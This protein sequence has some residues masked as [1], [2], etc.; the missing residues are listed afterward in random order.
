MIEGAHVLVVV[1]RAAA[2]AV[3]TLDAQ[4]ERNAGHETDG[5]D[6]GPH[7]P[8]DGAQG[9]WRRGRRRIAV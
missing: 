4:Q 8:G 1:A 5:A 2:A 6:R 3:A 9:K 7:P